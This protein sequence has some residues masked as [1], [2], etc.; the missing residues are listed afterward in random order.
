VGTA[1]NQ[2]T[3]QQDFR[4]F[5]GGV[6]SVTQRVAWAAAEGA[7]NAGVVTSSPNVTDLRR[8]RDPSPKR[9]R[10]RYR[11]GVERRRR[12]DHLAHAQDKQ[13]DLATKEHPCTCTPNS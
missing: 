3:R 4:Q 8:C 12:P 2:R 10:D 9:P 7:A 6:K 13:V 1:Y 11:V 5:M